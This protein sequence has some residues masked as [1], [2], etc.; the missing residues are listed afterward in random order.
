[1]QPPGAA[2]VE[3]VLSGAAGASLILPISAKGFW[4]KQ[5]R[6]LPPVYVTPELGFLKRGVSL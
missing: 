1:M 5:E 2:P 6:D 3:L 4:L